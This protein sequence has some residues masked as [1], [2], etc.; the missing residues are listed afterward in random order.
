MKVNARPER[1]LF[2]EGFSYGKK[3]GSGIGLYIV[4]KTIE[5]YGG[6][7]KVFNDNRAVFV[8]KL[9]SAERK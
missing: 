1:K 9:K 4:R 6:E 7:V 2:T 8:I 3:A 5:R